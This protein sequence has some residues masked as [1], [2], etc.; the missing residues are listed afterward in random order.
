MTKQTVVGGTMIVV[1]VIMWI[2]GVGDTIKDLQDWHGLATPAVI[3]ELLKQAA[4]IALSALGGT[5]LPGVGS[6]SVDHDILTVDL[7][8]AGKP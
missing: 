5:L 1:A 8:K 4:T 7:Q 3:G 2:S 6:A